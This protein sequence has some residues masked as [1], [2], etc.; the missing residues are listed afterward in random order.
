MKYGMSDRQIQ[1]LRSRFS[2]FACCRSPDP[3][4]ARVPPPPPPNPHLSVVPSTSPLH[5]L[6]GTTSNAAA[7]L[8]PLATLYR[9]VPH[10][11]LPSTSRSTPHTCACCL[12]RV[13][14]SPPL[15]TS[16]PW[17]HHGCRL[18]QRYRPSFFLLVDVFDLNHQKVLGCWN[19]I[20]K[21]YWINKLSKFYIWLSSVKKRNQ[22]WQEPWE[23]YL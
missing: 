3:C 12:L 10:M 16:V 20:R 22:I 19:L 14:S 15:H 2:S 17:R 4:H 1:R 8:I 5:F 23:K 13:S 11:R 9:V 6:P 18:R 7:S 21:E